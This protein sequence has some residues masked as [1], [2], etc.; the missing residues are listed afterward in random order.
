MDLFQLQS[1]IRYLFCQNYNGNI[2]WFRANF[3]GLVQF[4]QWT[5]LVC[6]N[7]ESE[8]HPLSKATV[9]H[10]DA[11]NII[12]SGETLVDIMNEHPCKLNDDVLGVINSFW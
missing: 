4:Q 5:T 7:E 9:F 6:N 2:T 12:V 3:L 11:N 8:Y 10:M 1:K